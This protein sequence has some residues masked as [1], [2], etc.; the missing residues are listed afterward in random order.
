MARTPELGTG[1]RGRGEED[2]GGGMRGMSGS[3]EGGSVRSII[4]FFPVFSK[5]T[6]T[7][8]CVGVFVLDILIY[9]FLFIYLFILL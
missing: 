2:E 8:L 9:V 3:T 1:D 7:K 6:M 4:V 5:E